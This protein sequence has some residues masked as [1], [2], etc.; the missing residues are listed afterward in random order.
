MKT[1][2]SKSLYGISCKTVKIAIKGGHLQ[3][4]SAHLLFQQ[5]GKLTI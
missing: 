4:A 3:R 2:I 5:S 1:V